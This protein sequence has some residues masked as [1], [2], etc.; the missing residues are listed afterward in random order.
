MSRLDPSGPPGRTA[1]A[2]NS[3]AFASTGDAKP[4][5]VRMYH[6]RL[7]IGESTLAFERDCF[8]G[9]FNEEQW[10]LWRSPPVSTSG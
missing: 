8:G 10:P 6:N 4:R 1:W 2:A 5:I 9:G 3:C 7:V